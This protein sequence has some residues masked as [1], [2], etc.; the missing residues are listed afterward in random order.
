MSGIFV[1]IAQPTPNATVRRN[2]TVSGSFAQFRGSVWGSQIQ[3]GVGGPTVTAGGGAW[4]FFWSGNIPNN[5][6]P[7]QSFQIIVSAWGAMRGP[8][9]V[10]GE[11]GEDI[12]VDGQAVQ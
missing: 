4:S 12:P 11:P 7:G 6:R 9:I 1:F 10:P 3:F 8:D 2:I 5:I